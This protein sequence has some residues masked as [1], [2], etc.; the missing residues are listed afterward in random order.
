M[1]GGVLRE[2]EAVFATKDIEVVAD[3]SP[4]SIEC[5]HVKAGAHE[6]LQRLSVPL[7]TGN[8][9][10]RATDLILSVDVG[11][12]IKCLARGCHITFHACAKKSGLQAG[13][14]ITLSRSALALWT[15]VADTNPLPL[16]LTCKWRKRAN[17]AC[18]RNNRSGVICADAAKT[19]RQITV[20]QVIHVAILNAL[21]DFV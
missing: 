16:N 21:L 7:E 14:H 19:G 6:R 5:A 9:R 18:L 11:P 15:H 12:E 17:P 3:V 2:L 1:S 4:L 13:G 20:V 8:H 10:W